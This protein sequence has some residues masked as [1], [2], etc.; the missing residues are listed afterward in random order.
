MRTLAPATSKAIPAT[1]FV[2]GT[3]HLQALI[4]VPGSGPVDILTLHSRKVQ[5]VTV[6]DGLFS[7]TAA[8]GRYVLRGHDGDAAC[9]QVK[10]TVVS[11]E[12]VTAPAIVCQGS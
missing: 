10:V 5:T 1:G 7:F 3:E 8:P 11:A 12:R 4:V 9:P 2:S 6:L